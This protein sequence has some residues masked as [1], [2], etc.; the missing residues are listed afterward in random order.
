MMVMA[1]TYTSKT[2]SSSS[3][4]MIASSSLNDLIRTISQQSTKQQW[5]TTPSTVWINKGIHEGSSTNYHSLESRCCHLVQQSSKWTILSNKSLRIQGKNNSNKYNYNNNHHHHHHSFARLHQQ[6]R[7]N[8]ATTVSPSSSSSSSS[9]SSDS[10]IQHHGQQQYQRK[11]CVY[12]AVGSNL[13]DSYQNIHRGL[14]KLCDPNFS[15]Q[16]YLPTRWIK[17]SFLYRTKPMYV[18]DQPDFWNGAVQID[19]D[20]EPHTLLRRLKQIEQSMGRTITTASTSTSTATTT[21]NQQPTRNGPRPLDLDILLLYN[22]NQIQNTNTTTGARV[23]ATKT[24][25]ATITTQTNN[26]GQE[27]RSPIC[28]DSKDLIVPHPRIQEREFVLRPLIDVAGRQV[29]LPTYS[30]N[31][32]NNNTTIGELLDGII[33]DSSTDA[34]AVRILPLPHGRCLVFDQTIIMGILNVT[35][36]SFSDGG[37]SWTDNVD[38]AVDRAMTMIQDGAT[39]IDVGGESTRP[40]AL[41]ASVEEQ[42]RRT[43]PVIKRL[44]ERAETDVVVSID[45]RHAAV[46]RAA[47]QAGA[48]II[49]DVSGGTFDPDMLSTMAELQVPVVLMH[50]RGTPETMQSMTKYDE[51]GGVVQGVVNELLERSKAAEKAGIPNWMQILDLGI[52]FAKDLEG[53]LSLLKHYTEMQS[54]LNNVPLVLG[55]SRKGFIGKITGEDIAANRDYG[56]VGSCIA[57]LC[58]GRG[59]QATTTTGGK[60]GG[61][62]SSLG[63]HILRV[64]NVKAAK[65]AASLM[66]AIVRA[67]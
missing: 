45:T 54:R 67:D 44:K 19:T 9:S 60:G 3:S 22:Q 63:C 61:A 6:E 17:S 57:A 59:N 28:I 25:I 62:V 30:D 29:I 4:L 15:P 14:V 1:S 13:G 48:D 23:A 26:T 40:G 66:D 20:I 16:T 47:V 21:Y 36:D 10:D 49:N 43:I 11:Y 52:G 34:T 58:L 56:T 31:N 2:I 42:I 24:N 55:T 50:M 33:S 46:A 41:E 38:A 35:P 65:H 51:Q 8:F 53:N 12:L 37:S 5:T 7:R 27:Q 18:T 64:H 39:I 32:N